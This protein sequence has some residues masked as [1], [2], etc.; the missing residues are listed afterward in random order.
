MKRCSS[1]LIKWVWKI[2]YLVLPWSRCYYDLH[3]FS[4]DLNQLSSCRGDNGQCCCWCCFTDWTVSEQWYWCSVSCDEMRIEMHISF[5]QTL[6][7]VL[8]WS[9]SIIKL[10]WIEWT[11]VLL[12]STFWNTGRVVLCT[13]WC[14]VC[15]FSLTKAYAQAHPETGALFM[16]H[17][18]TAV[19]GRQNWR[20]RRVIEYQCPCPR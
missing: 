7:W 1:K 16:F 10:C 2:C 6:I 11:M 15:A 17:L 8:S 19:H 9:T 12:H 13:F 14:D 3:N 5:S 20:L 4:S 18:E